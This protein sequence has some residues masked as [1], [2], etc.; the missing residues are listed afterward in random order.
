M[1][2]NCTWRKKLADKLVQVC[3]ETVE[4]VKMSIK[5]N[6][7][8]AHC[9]L[10]CFQYSL[11]STLELVL[12]LFTINTWIAIKKLLL[13]MIMSIKQQL[14]WFIKIQNGGSKKN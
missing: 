5:T 10:C 3:A 1:D 2:L 6:V 12:I 11:Q 8:L 9:T 7:V 14:N 13:D 4:K